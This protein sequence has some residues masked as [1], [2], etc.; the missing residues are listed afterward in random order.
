MR[1]KL[2]FQYLSQPSSN[3]TGIAF[4]YC[5]AV[6]LNTPVWINKALLWASNAFSKKKNYNNKKLWRRTQLY[7][8]LLFLK[9]S[10]SQCFMFLIFEFK[11]SASHMLNNDDLFTL[12]T[13]TLQ[14]LYCMWDQICNAQLW[15]AKTLCTVKLRKILLATLRSMAKWLLLSNRNGFSPLNASSNWNLELS[16]M[17]RETSSFSFKLFLQ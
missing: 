11:C 14:L 4:H 8:F 10:Y 7:W 17:E 1:I 9:F 15:T 3:V 2:D 5:Q 12:H 16:L 13:H 6:S